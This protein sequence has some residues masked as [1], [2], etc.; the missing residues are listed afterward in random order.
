MATPI[1][2]ALILSVRDGRKL[3]IRLR[4]QHEELSNNA[5]D[6]IQTRARTLVSPALGSSVIGTSH[7]P[8]QMGSLCQ[9]A[10][11]SGCRSPENWPGV[12]T[13]DLNGGVTPGVTFQIPQSGHRHGVSLYVNRPIRGV[14]QGQR[15][16]AACSSS[17]GEAGVI[18]PV[19][20]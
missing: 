5:E 6:R 18:T 8:G 20:A 2:A 7:S 14:R 9:M 10:M 15:N 11:S 13:L 19:P 4:K 3:T 16:T 17:R 12:T 1:P